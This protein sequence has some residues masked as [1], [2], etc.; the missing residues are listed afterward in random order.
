[1]EL[2]VWMSRV[3]VALCFFVAVIVVIYDA[4]RK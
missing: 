4:V 1:M 3:I 2:M